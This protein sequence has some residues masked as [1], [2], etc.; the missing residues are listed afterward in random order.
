MEAE[1][2]RIADARRRMAE[3]RAE[4][5]PPPPAR[6]PPHQRGA[7]P[8]EA[9]VE[10]GTVKGAP[11]FRMPTQDLSGRGQPKQ[12]ARDRRGRRQGPAVDSVSDGS[13]AVNPN[14]KPPKR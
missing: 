2:R 6:R 7:R 11:A 3:A 8:P 12:V 10:A 4:Q 1:G 13:A 5:P 9:A 14:F